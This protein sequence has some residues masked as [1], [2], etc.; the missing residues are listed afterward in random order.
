[1][2]TMPSAT[3]V[4]VPSLRASADSLTFSMRLLMSALISDGLS[5]VIAMVRFLVVCRRRR[6]SDFY[7]CSWPVAADWWLERAI[8]LPATHRRSPVT[9]S[10]RQRRLQA[11][12]LAAQRSVDDHVAGCDHR[13][14]D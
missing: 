14:A 12:Q 13:A 6:H 1:M 5:V 7:V 3:D 4:T 10:M 11:R 9:D 8:A 2:R